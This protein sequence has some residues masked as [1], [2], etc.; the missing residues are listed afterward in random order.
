MDW[1]WVQNRTSW[2]ESLAN[3][4][5]THSFK[6]RPSQARLKIC[7]VWSAVSCKAEPD[8]DGNVEGPAMDGVLAWIGTLMVGMGWGSPPPKSRG[9]ASSDL[10]QRTSVLRWGQKTVCGAQ[11]RMWNGTWAEAA[12]ADTQECATFTPA[13]WTAAYPTS[14]LHFAAVHWA[15][16]P[17]WSLAFAISDTLIIMVFVPW[18][19]STLPIWIMSVITLFGFI[20]FPVTI[21]LRSL[22]LDL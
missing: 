11:L 22:S 5:A 14:L 18:T 4:L 20:T 9:E 19:A 16:M 7:L 13:W 6:C 3:S 10:D 15:I 12:E 8:T 1:A 21:L 17:A 2:L